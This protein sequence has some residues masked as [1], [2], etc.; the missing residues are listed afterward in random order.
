MR[1]VAIYPVVWGDYRKKMPSMEERNV[2]L[3]PVLALHG[4]AVDFPQK[5]GKATYHFHVTS[6]DIEIHHHSYDGIAGLWCLPPESGDEEVTVLHSGEDADI[7][8][9]SRI[10]DCEPDYVEI[11]N[12]HFGKRAVFSYSEVNSQHTADSGCAGKMDGILPGFD[13]PHFAPVGR[14]AFA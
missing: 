1:R 14:R 13:S 4:Y 10:H 8:I 12:R 2:T 9:D 3:H 7:T 11:A 5:P 6:G